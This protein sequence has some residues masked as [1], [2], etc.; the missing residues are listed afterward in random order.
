ML[1]D[2]DK[3]KEYLGINSPN[4]DSQLIFL[5]EYVNQYILEFCGLGDVSDTEVEHTRRVTS[6]SG[7][8]AVL[9]STRISSVTSVLDRGVE[10]AEE[11]YFLDKDTG[12]IVFY[13]PVTTKPFGISVTYT[14]PAFEPPQDLVFA[15]L[16]LVKYFHKDEYK[17]SASTGQGDS[18]SF[19]V[20]KS[21]PNKIRHIL[22]QHRPL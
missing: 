6:S 5:V 17:N 21:I 19:E 13:T 4:K 22:V 12:I 10:V 18:I 14:I 3:T 8:N 11:D 20:T 9:P 15:A 16:E 2:L 1:I 7:R